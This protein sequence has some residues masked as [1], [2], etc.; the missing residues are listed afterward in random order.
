MPRRKSAVTAGSTARAQGS[1]MGY[2]LSTSMKRDGT[3]MPEGAAEKA[4]PDGAGPPTDNLLVKEGSSGKVHFP[5]GSFLLV[6]DPLPRL[7]EQK[8]GSC[9]LV[10]TEAVRRLEG[11]A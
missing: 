7:G 2:R 3:A 11:I 9:Q 8:C 1:E 4:G 10:F 5:A 6:T